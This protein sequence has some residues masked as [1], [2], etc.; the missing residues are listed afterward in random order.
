MLLLVF[1]IL[2]LFV[3]IPFVL[4]GFFVIWDYSYGWLIYMSVYSMFLTS[5]FFIIKGY[6]TAYDVK[7]FSRQGRLYIPVKKSTNKETNVFICNEGAFTS[8]LAILGL[9]VT[10]LFFL[11]EEVWGGV[12]FFSIILLLIL[13][14]KSKILIDKHNGVHARLIYFAGFRIKQ[15]WFILPDID[16]VRVKKLRLGESRYSKNFRYELFIDFTTE[17]EQL[18]IHETKSKK[19][20]DRT[21]ALLN[22]YLRS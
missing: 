16:K 18:S 13:L 19:K 3:S 5:V 17:T 15:S 10:L 7:L 4:G 14:V 1:G 6:E 9:V 8:I 20:N 11:I 2:L 22:D 12:L 21:R